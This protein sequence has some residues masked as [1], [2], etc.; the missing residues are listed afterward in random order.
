M[1]TECLTKNRIYYGNSDVIQCR[2]E[3]LN[4]LSTFLCI[5]VYVCELVGWVIEIPRH[6]KIMRKKSMPQEIIR[7]VI[8]ASLPGTDPGDE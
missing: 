1:V 7:N 3:L 8:Q 5:Y 6:L 4:L 2:A